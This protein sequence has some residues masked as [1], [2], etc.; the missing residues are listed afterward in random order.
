MHSNSGV[1]ILLWVSENDSLRCYTES[2]AS[3]WPVGREQ[4]RSRSFYR[5]PMMTD[6]SS[7]PG[8]DQDYLRRR[9]SQERAAAEQA[10]D[11]A[12]RHAHITLADEYAERL[13]IVVP[14]AA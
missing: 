8:Q 9:E 1:E 12:A 2:S 5:S 3:E 10:I 14:V 7:P 6:Q 11:P 4:H 13:R